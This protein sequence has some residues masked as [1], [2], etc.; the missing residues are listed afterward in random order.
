MTK[1]LSPRLLA[2]LAAHNSAPMQDGDPL[3]SLDSD[4]GDTSTLA[5]PMAV[6]RAATGHPTADDT[7][8]ILNDAWALAR[9]ATYWTNNPPPSHFASTMNDDLVRLLRATG[10]RPDVGQPPL[11]GPR[12]L[13]DAARA[14]FTIEEASE[15]LASEH[16]LS[17]L[18]RHW[19]FDGPTQAVL[20]LSEA[21][22]P[23]GAIHRELLI[24]C[25]QLLATRNRST[26]ALGA[27]TG[28]APELL[29]DDNG[30]EDRTLVIRRLFHDDGVMDIAIESSTVDVDETFPVVALL[31]LAANKTPRRLLF[32]LIRDE[33]GALTRSYAESRVPIDPDLTTEILFLYNRP[34]QASDLEGQ[35]LEAVSDS[36]AAAKLPWK[37]AWRRAALST[38][39]GHP[40]RNEVAKGLSQL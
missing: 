23:I 21:L 24:R 17:H 18:K 31:C 12:N 35:A 16:L 29:S 19:G 2:D 15:I 39:T 20:H 30:S 27:S 3:P 6:V 37:D 10:I 22:D 5:S 33:E 14:G 25:G 40:L 1:H 11:V 4:A 13:F 7:F 34:V 8:R 36:V 28:T 26:Y 38:P 32:L 9:L